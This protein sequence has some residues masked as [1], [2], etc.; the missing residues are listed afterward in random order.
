[1]GLGSLSIYAIWVCGL[2]ISAWIVQS[3]LAVVDKLY[4]SARCLELVVTRLQALSVTSRDM[5]S[6]RY[7]QTG[8]DTLWRSTDI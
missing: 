7:D 2:L 1:M 3:I 5:G 4:R 6:R 8:I